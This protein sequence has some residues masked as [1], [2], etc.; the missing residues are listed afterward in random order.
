VAPDAVHSQSRRPAPASGR[1]RRPTAP[2]DKQLPSGRHGLSPRYVAGNQRRRILDALVEV[3]AAHGYQA[4]TVERVAARAGVSRRTF[5]EQFADRESAYLALY[6]GAARALRT[7]VELAVADMPQRCATGRLR[8][9]LEALLDGLASASELA[10]VC[11]V[12][13]LS[14]GPAAI[15]RR[16]AVMGA[17]AALLDDVARACDG[18]PLPPLTAEGIVGAVHDVVYKRVAAG[19]TAELPGLLDDLHRFCLMLFGD[20]TDPRPA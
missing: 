6:D 4:A 8:A 9:G 10:F 5:Y 17:F 19:E 3:V 14:A 1:P 2:H 11:V 16:D 13:V 15:E 12:G 18:A 7:R 20:A